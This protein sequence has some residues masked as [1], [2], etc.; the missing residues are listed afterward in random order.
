MFTDVMKHAAT[1]AA[2]AAAAET[3]AANMAVCACVA[4]RVFAPI[5]A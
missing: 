1:A 5:T 4:D 3:G 2:V